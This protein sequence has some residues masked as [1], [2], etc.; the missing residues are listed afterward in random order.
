MKAIWTGATI[1]LL[2]ETENEKYQLERE[3]GDAWDV[4]EF[5]Y[6]K[7]K[8]FVVGLARKPEQ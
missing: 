5:D 4:K 1:L 8:F 2:P 7:Q 6:K 3:A